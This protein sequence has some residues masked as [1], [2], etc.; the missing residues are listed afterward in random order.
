MTFEELSISINL[1][2]SQLSPADMPAYLAGQTFSPRPFTDFM[3]RKFREKRLPQKEIFIR[4]DLD[5]RYGYKLISGEK[6]TQQRDII[7]RICL[8]A[9]FTLGEAQEALVLYG[10]APLYEKV[11]RD[12]AFIV[13]FSNRIYD[14]H[15]VDTILRENDLP[16]FLLPDPD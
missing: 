11:R 9:E 3:R 5:D 13:A 15:E 16:P 2:V 14:I 6:Q 1:A 8:A 12:T 10:M 7:L 4:A